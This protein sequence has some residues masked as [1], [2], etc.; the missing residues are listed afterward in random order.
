[1]EQDSVLPNPSSSQYMFSK[2]FVKIQK[3]LS[4]LFLLCYARVMQAGTRERE[5]VTGGSPSVTQNLPDSHQL[6]MYSN[7]DLNKYKY[8]QMKIPC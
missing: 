2:A 6:E 7:T 5:A 8:F 4:K 1:M 3:L